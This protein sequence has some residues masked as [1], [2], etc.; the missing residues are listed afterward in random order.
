[1]LVGKEQWG[2]ADVKH[3]QDLGEEKLALTNL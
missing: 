2:G 1:M 3:P